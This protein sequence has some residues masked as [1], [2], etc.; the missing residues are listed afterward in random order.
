VCLGPNNN[1]NNKCHTDVGE[2][3]AAILRL[4]HCACLPHDFAFQIISECSVGGKDMGVGGSRRTGGSVG[5][6]AVM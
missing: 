1:Q 2:Q 5:A 3:V 4:P 6:R